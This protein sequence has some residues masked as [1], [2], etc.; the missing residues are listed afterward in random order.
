[1][2]VCDAKHQNTAGAL[3]H[4]ASVEC[5]VMFYT[6]HLSGA[7][8][9]LSQRFD[10][11]QAHLEPNS[12]PAPPEGARRSEGCS[13][14]RSVEDDSGITNAKVFWCYCAAHPL[15]GLRA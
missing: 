9:R 7:L 10:L 5:G 3:C 1:M 15:K 14:R 4:H 6:G 11:P 2:S 12:L 8:E 13:D